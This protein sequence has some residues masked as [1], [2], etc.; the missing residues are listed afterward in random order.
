M[1]Q[2]LVLAAVATAHQGAGGDGLPGRGSTRRVTWRPVP[3]HSLVPAAST[4]SRITRIVVLLNTKVS[5]SARIEFVKCVIQTF[6]VG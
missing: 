3:A 2:S 1:G 5:L 4:Y 6:T